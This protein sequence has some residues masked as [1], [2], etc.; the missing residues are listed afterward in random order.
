MHWLEGLS[1]SAA[2]VGKKLQS[3]EKTMHSK[4]Y[5]DEDFVT[6][7]LRWLEYELAAEPEDERARR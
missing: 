1:V 6:W 4:R 2:V 7:V 5:P 3:M